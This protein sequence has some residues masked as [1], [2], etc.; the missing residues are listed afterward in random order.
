VQGI[1]ENHGVTLTVHSEGGRGSTFRIA[2]P[3]VVKG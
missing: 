2:L 1:V 3:L